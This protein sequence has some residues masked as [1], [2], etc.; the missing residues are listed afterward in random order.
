MLYS[1]I[2]ICTPLINTRD[3]DIRINR[4]GQNFKKILFFEFTGA[5]SYS[6]I[7]YDDRNSSVHFITVS[8]RHGYDC[9]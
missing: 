7:L 6:C 2:I 3:V 4:N 8:G 5:I 9:C 1:N